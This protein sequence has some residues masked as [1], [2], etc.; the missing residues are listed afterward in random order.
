M[1]RSVMTHPD[2]I[3][4]A[5]R[6]LDHGGYCPACEFLTCADEG[7]DCCPECGGE[8]EPDYSGDFATSEFEYLVDWIRDTFTERFPSM[9]KCD[10][11]AHGYGAMNELHCIVAN[12]LCDVYIAEYCGMV[13]IS[14]VPTG[15]ASYSEDT[16]GLA[17]G[18]T[19]RYATP[20]LNEFGEYAPV[21][22]ASNGETFYRRVAA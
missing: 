6:T 16:T 7:T 3:A 9:D 19:E 5:Y 12:N 21:A 22:T 18:W 14:L 10:R 8:L 11:W 17:R 2:A 4:V 15:E 1:G 20:A 13:S